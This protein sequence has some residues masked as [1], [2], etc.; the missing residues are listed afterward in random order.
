M[1][2]KTATP[3]AVPKIASPTS[4]SHIHSSLNNATTPINSPEAPTQ[5]QKHNVTSVITS[6]APTSSSNMSRKEAIVVTSNKNF[7]DN[8]EKE[9]NN[10]NNLKNHRKTISHTDTTKQETKSTNQNNKNKISTHPQETITN[11]TSTIITTNNYNEEPKNN[12]SQ[13]HESAE[14]KIVILSKHK[15][16]SKSTKNFTNES[17]DEEEDDDEL[18]EHEKMDRL[19]AKVKHLMGELEKTKLPTG[20]C[21]IEINRKNIFEVSLSLIAFN[22]SLVLNF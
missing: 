22:D 19:G 4:S 17:E 7:I 16:N 2:S 15:L 9:I 18:D 3:K 20:H 13:K 11:T 10:I 8:I 1:P 21:R 14:N 5:N 6:S 12:D